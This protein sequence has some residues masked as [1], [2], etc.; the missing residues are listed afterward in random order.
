M[1]VDSSFSQIICVFDGESY[2]L[3]KV[4]MKSYMESLHLWDVVEEN[5]GVPP[6]A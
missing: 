4:K 1:D 2:D 6:F 5:Y 3:W